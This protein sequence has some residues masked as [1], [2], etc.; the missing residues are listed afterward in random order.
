M[1]RV[2]RYADTD[3]PL[4]LDEITAGAAR[5]IPGA[6]YA[7]VTVTTDKGTV[8]TAAST[9][10][11]PAIL[12]DV[13]HNLQE[14]P[15]FQT[16]A[17]QNPIRIDALGRESRWPRYRDVALRRTPIRA[18][19]TFGLLS[20]THFLGTLNVYSDTPDA[21]DDEAFDIAQAYATHAS[22]AWDALRRKEQFATALATRDIIGQAKGIIMERYRC[23]ADHAF[24]LL[25]KLSQETNRP[26]RDIARQLVDADRPIPDVDDAGANV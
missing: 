17:D 16:A 24:G 22:L 13:Q 18:V 4:A 6:Q 15:Y 21:Y 2:Q 14:G 5:L 8:D 23:G 26:L 3:V 1:Q 19:M 9:H 11:Y 20:S 12:D 7:A 25:T 10:R